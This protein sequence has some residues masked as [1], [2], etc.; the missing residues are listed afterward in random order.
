MLMVGK[1]SKWN[2][3]AKKDC[4]RIEKER[5]DFR[6]EMFLTTLDGLAFDQYNGHIVSCL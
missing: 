3:P 4:R 5:Y 1:P 6:I 2:A